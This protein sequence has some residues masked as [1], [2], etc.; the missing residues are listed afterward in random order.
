MQTSCDRVEGSLWLTY[1]KSDQL[2]Y[3]SC[4]VI[5][6]LKVWFLMLLTFWS[7]SLQLSFGCGLAH[8]H[9]QHSRTSS[10]LAYLTFLSQTLRH[11]FVAFAA[12]LLSLSQ[13]LYFCS[14]NFPKIIASDLLPIA[15]LNTCNT[16]SM[17]GIHES[18]QNLLGRFI[19]MVVRSSCDQKSRNMFIL[20]QLSVSKS[21][22]KSENLIAFEATFTHEFYSRNRL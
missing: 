6:W 1:S 17:F 14:G 7:A 3:D 11:A 16:N 13:V 12:H 9:F 22:P 8:K 15:S 5:C 18:E 21:V 19:M 2:L 20:F 10:Q 4:C